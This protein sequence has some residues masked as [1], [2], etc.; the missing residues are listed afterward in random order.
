MIT[1]NP[2]QWFN[3]YMFGESPL[4]T[5]GNAPRDS[6]EEPG[7]HEWDFSIVKDTKLGFLGE[8]GNLQFRAEIFNVL[9]HAN[10]SYP[11]AVVFQGSTSAN[12]YT[13]PPVGE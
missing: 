1:G 11:S 13:P 3:P 12:S 7:L 2:N 5:V 9:N 10:F 6:L 8:G 4:G